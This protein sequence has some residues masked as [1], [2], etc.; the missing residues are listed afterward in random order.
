MLV[1]SES[2]FLRFLFFNIFGFQVSLKARFNCKHKK[3]KKFKPL[4]KRLF[5]ILAFQ[6]YFLPRPQTNRF[7][8]KDLLT[9]DSL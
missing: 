3:K 8:H 1:I 7:F 9:H 4:F 6:F 5:A 2:V